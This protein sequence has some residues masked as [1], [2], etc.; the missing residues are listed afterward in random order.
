MSTARLVKAINSFAVVIVEDAAGPGTGY[1]AIPTWAPVAVLIG[2]T[3]PE[4]FLREPDIW[5]PIGL[6]DTLLDVATL[7]AALGG[8]SGDSILESVLALTK[9]YVQDRITPDRFVPTA[10]TA[11]P[12]A[13][14]GAS[15]G[16]KWPVVTFPKG[17][18]TTQGATAEFN[19]PRGVTTA[20]LK[21]GWF[22]LSAVS[23]NDIVR[24]T[25][26]HLPAVAIGDQVQVAG[27]T[28]ASA[29]GANLGIGI[30][31]ETTIGTPFAVTAGK[32]E[33]LVVQRLSGSPEETFLGDVDLLWAEIT[34]A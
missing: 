6:D 2:T 12:T 3:D 20:A 27:S 13:V 33:R 34:F 31:Q 21:L 8:A 28:I 10:G 17:A 4:A 14:Y 5:V 30:Y 7:V 1:A 22:G 29:N 16:Q 9:P 25:A 19:V 26:T 24:W 23:G 15:I 11:D 18:P 32:T